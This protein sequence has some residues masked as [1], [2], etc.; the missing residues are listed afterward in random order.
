VGVCGLFFFIVGYACLRKDLLIQSVSGG[1]QTMIVEM[2]F[3]S[4]GQ[5][6]SGIVIYTLW[7]HYVE[8]IDREG[9]ELL[10]GIW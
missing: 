9:S 8:K 1:F 10:P 7:L 4:R 5:Q 6:G 2:I 3:R